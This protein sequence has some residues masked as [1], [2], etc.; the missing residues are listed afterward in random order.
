MIEFNLRML[1]VG[2]KGDVVEQVF[3]DGVEPSRAD[4]FGVFV[5]EKC[6][7]RNLASAR[8]A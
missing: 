8:P 6:E 3:H 5:G 1:A 2:V 4:V 7:F